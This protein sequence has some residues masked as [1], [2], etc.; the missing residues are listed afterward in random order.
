MCHLGRVENY[1]DRSLD[2]SKGGISPKHAKVS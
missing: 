2:M 1:R